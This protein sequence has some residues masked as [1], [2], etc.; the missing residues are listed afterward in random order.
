MY[1]FHEGIS[2]AKKRR[3]KNTNE[4]LI[5]VAYIVN[6]VVTVRTK[7]ISLPSVFCTDA[8]VAGGIYLCHSIPIDTVV[9][10]SFR[11]SRP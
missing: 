5:Y 11:N 9:Y 6:T 8:L 7:V 2:V 10:F 3:K 1:Q 4:L